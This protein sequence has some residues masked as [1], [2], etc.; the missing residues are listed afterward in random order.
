MKSQR[1]LGSVARFAT[2]NYFHTMMILFAAIVFTFFT[3]KEYIPTGFRLVMP[4]VLFLM[5]TATVKRTWAWMLVL[6]SIMLVINA[7]LNFYV[8]ANH[9]FMIAYISLALLIA[10]CADD[11]ALMQKMALWFLTVL[12]G[13]ALIQ[14]LA[15]PYYMS[16]N[17][18]G[19]Y[20][21]TGQMFK[22]LITVAHPDWVNVVHANIAAKRELAAIL[23]STGNSV[24]LA[25]PAGITAL[26]MG[27]TYTAL[28]SQFLM[29]AALL[30]RSRMGIWVHY[31]LLLF[32]LIIYSTRNENV[33]LSMNCI[34]GYALTDAQ[35]K[36]ARKFY[37][38]WIFYLLAME[39][40]GV[41]PGLLI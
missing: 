26:I 31:A 5:I 37:V 35:T 3:T 41:R 25:V 7:V 33:F 14:K 17:L 16:G 34:L 11:Q 27:L 23:P 21:L 18:I 1:Y 12:M 22:N 13:L 20:I 9:G 19:D 6:A 28:V 2:D 29:E 39:M 24:P 40:M 4:W 8:S 36:S 38:I 30:A 15:S 32:V 10:V